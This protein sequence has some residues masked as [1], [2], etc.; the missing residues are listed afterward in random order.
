MKRKLG[1]GLVFLLILVLIVTGTGFT[2]MTGG[3]WFYDTIII[4]EEGEIV[5]IIFT[6]NMISVAFNGQPQEGIYQQGDGYTLTNAKGQLQ[7]IDHATGDRIHCKIVATRDTGKPEASFY[8]GPAT[9]NGDDGYFVGV[10]F[11]NDTDFGEIGAGDWVSVSLHDEGS[12]TVVKSYAGFL[13]G[14]TAKQK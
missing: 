2:K 14:G 8:A 4:A 3:G 13:V 9:F 12:M 1:L 6:E 5:D 10:E 11:H 7:L